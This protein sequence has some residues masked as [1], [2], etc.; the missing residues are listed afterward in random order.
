VDPPAHVVSEGFSIQVAL[1][2]QAAVRLKGINGCVHFKGM[3]SG[4]GMSVSGTRRVGSDSREDAE[5]HLAMLQVAIEEGA[6]EILVESRHPERDGRSYEVEYTVSLPRD[7]KVY[8]ENTNGDVTLEGLRE[9]ATVQL[10]NGRVRADLTLPPFG[11]IDLF[12]VNGDID[13]EVQKDASAQFK[14]TLTNGQITASDLELG[15]RV[16]TRRSLM[17]RLGDGAGLIQLGLV[18][19]DIRA[20]GR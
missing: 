9:D 10:T 1:S 17:G 16:V 20:K 15:D 18:N 19:G 8:V 7:L 2:G 13:L 12:T 4:E 6:E 11:L 3:D 14:A 5:A